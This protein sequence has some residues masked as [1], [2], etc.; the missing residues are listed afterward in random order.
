LHKLLELSVVARHKKVKPSFHFFMSIY[1]SSSDLEIWQAFKGGDD[2]AYECIYHRHARELFSYGFH[3][4]NDRQLVEDCVHDLFVYLF[5]HRSTLGDTN[6][7]KYYLFKSL[8]RRVVEVLEKQTRVAHESHNVAD[9]YHNH[10]LA[11]SSEEVKIIEAEA[12]LAQNRRLT[13]AIEKLPPRQKEAIYLLYFS[14]LEYEE[15][16]AIMSLS[17]RTVYNQIHTAI[18][19]LRRDMGRTDLNRLP[20]FLE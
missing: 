16:A 11:T 18:Q 7:I 2:H 4:V 9:L 13:E 19:T 17:I 8:R 3:I 14:N 1:S 12:N 6:A 10:E 20:V 5:Q 15:I